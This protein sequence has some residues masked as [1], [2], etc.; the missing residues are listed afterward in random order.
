MKT[1]FSGRKRVRH[2]IFPRFRSSEIVLLRP[3]FVRACV[4]VLQVSIPLTAT[5]ADTAIDA[6]ASLLAIR[7]HRIAKNKK[8]WHR[9]GK[10]LK[11]SRRQ[12][13]RGRDSSSKVLG[14]CFISLSFLCLPR[15]IGGLSERRCRFSERFQCP[16]SFDRDSVPVLPVMRG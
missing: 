16:P 4:R 6:F 12:T 14:R 1:S 15:A 3:A 10:V 13:V 8:V 11:I 9:F 2:K 5:V 7:N